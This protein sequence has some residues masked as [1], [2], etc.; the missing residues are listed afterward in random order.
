MIS[1][2]LALL[3]MVTAQPQTPDPTAPARKAYSICLNDFIRT[4]L[5]SK[6]KPGDFDATVGGACTDK[7]DALKA[8]MLADE[9]ASGA[10][11]DEAQRAADDEVQ[12]HVDNARVLYRDYLETGSRPES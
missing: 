4:N 9:R 2:A 10:S 6:A 3:L 7:R 12:D 8:A 11:Q 1:S 5:S